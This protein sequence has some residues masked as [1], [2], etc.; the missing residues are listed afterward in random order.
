MARRT[1]LG[2]GL[3]LA[4]LAAFVCV[5]P[6][7]YSQLP[8]PL[9]PHEVPPHPPKS[10]GKNQA[11][12]NTSN[13]A[14]SSNANSANKL[15]NPNAAG[16]QPNLQQNGKPGPGAP[17]NAR[18]MAGLPPKWVENLQEMSPEEQDRFLQNNQRFHNL[19]PE[20]QQQIRQRLQRWNRL[21][22]E[23][24]NALRD[25]ERIFERMTPEQR[26]HIQ[27]E[28]LPKWQQLPL[29]RRQ[30]LI[31]RLRT[32]RGLSDSER[33]A[34]LNDPRFMQGLTRDEQGMLRDLN[35]LRNPPNP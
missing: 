11:A 2:L 24:R 15:A 22:P 23:E 7:A 21:T 26:Q 16:G 9:K 33:Q 20:R 8:R 4:L 31:G 29:D 34:R 30:R 35:T 14:D 27:Q 28:L 12:K 18:G 3:T 6:P 5:P 25:R 17:S 19:P 1:Q 10:A 13:N 32:L